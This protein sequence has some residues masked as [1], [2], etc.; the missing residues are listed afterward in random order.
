M[1]KDDPRRYPDKESIG[2]F[3]EHGGH[4]A[5]FTE[6]FRRLST[7]IFLHDAEP[8]TFG[9]CTAE[10]ILFIADMSMC[11]TAQ[12]ARSAMA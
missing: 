8:G 5:R 7:A 2:I 9:C 1:V 4:L 10:S 3:G 6:A 12:S 11:R